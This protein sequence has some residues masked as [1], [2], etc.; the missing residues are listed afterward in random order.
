MPSF[1]RQQPLDKARGLVDEVREVTSKAMLGGTPADGQDVLPMAAELQT[2]IMYTGPARVGLQVSPVPS[3]GSERSKLSI[4]RSHV[5][6]DVRKARMCKGA[7]DAEG[8]RNEAESP[9]SSRLD[10]MVFFERVAAKAQAAEGQRSPGS[11]GMMSALSVIAR[12]AKPKA[13]HPDSEFRVMLD[14]IYFGAGIYTL[15]AA[16]FLVSFGIEQPQGAFLLASGLSDAV[17]VADLVFNLNTGFVRVEKGETIVVLDVWPAA[18]HYASRGLLM[19]AVIALPVIPI[20]FAYFYFFGSDP[21]ALVSNTLRILHLCKMLVAT[22]IKKIFIKFRISNPGWNFEISL[23]SSVTFVI[24]LT[25]LVACLFIV[26]ASS[27]Y[28]APNDLFLK[29][30]ATDDVDECA[31]NAH[32]CDAAQAICTNTAGS[33]VCTCRHGLLGN[34]TECFECSEYGGA[35]SQMTCRLFGEALAEPLVYSPPTMEHILSGT[36]VNDVNE[37]STGAHNCDHHASC[38]NTPGSF[39]CHCDVGFVGPG[40]YC[41][42]CHDPDSVLNHMDLYHQYACALHFSLSI[43][44]LV[45]DGYAQPKS[46]SQRLVFCL[47]VFASVFFIA[48]I[49]SRCVLG[50]STRFDPY[51]MYLADRRNMLQFYACKVHAHPE[52]KRQ[53]QACF[54][55]HWDKLKTAPLV[56]SRILGLLLPPARITI[57]RSLHE[58]AFSSVLFFGDKR[59]DNIFWSFIL[60]HAQVVLHGDGHL[61]SIKDELESNLYFIKSG[62]VREVEDG[63]TNRVLKRPCHFGDGALLMACANSLRFVKI[64]VVANGMVELF[65]I[66]A[67]SLKELV[68]RDAAIHQGCMDFIHD[69]MQRYVSVKFQVLSKK[70]CSWAVKRA[71][72][73]FFSAN[74]AHPKLRPRAVGRLR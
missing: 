39:S 13:F 10:S 11:S 58:D 57:F 34:G 48:F 24:G 62:S 70:L 44:L 7:Y 21:S 49:A 61:I 42:S 46:S 40:E 35:F 30:F 71:R 25:H 9:G 59:R 38:I 64:N 51:E 36:Y 2:P 15:F 65:V 27:S 55:Y 16:L 3:D 69:E 32:N 23:V 6:T 52:G 12:R 45:G 68:D 29:I 4:V 20:Q 26:F 37:C 17:L 53:A 74:M 50:T 56:E 41:H 28:I 33:F 72:L 18:M 8:D 54:D 31:T 14:M 19:D 73:D 47:A 63:K 66:A 43:G 60:K 5:S 22:R 1:L 67:D